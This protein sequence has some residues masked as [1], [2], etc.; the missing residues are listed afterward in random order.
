MMNF[1]INKIFL[2]EN[3][4]KIFLIERN[5]DEIWTK[6]GRNL[7]LLIVN[8]FITTKQDTGRKFISE[9]FDYNLQDCS[10]INT[11]YQINH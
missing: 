4:S 2:I 11:F 10:R 8:N 6:S 1:Y 9:N 3:F 7:R 5:L